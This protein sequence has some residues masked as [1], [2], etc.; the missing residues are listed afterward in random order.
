MG[1]LSEVQDFREWNDEAD[2]GF[3]QK[4]KERLASPFKVA[5]QA[6]AELGVWSRP[7]HPWLGPSVIV[8]LP[9]TGGW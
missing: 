9:P 2:R 4:K 5:A 7:V 6:T 1:K 8:V 3:A